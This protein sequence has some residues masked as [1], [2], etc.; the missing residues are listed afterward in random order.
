IALRRASMGSGMRL[1]DL[2][3]AVS[4]ALDG[5]AVDGLDGGECR[6]LAELRFELRQD[7]L[8][9]FPYCLDPAVGKVADETRDPQRLGG[10]HREVAVADSLDPPAH[11]VAV[12]C[13]HRA[14]APEARRLSAGPSTSPCRPWP[15]PW[16][17]PW[18]WP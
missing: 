13:R 16:P 14:G 6:A 9:T 18:P 4:A 12:G 5:S 2:E 7:L 11:E 1:A 3:A 17:W 8:G 15:S 10:A